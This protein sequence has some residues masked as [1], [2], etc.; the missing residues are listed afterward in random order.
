MPTEP[1]P[2]ASLPEKPLARI[3]AV[4]LLLL[5]TAAVRGGSPRPLET[6]Q[7][8]DVRR[9]HSRVIVKTA[10]GGESS[11]NW[12][13]ITEDD[14]TPVAP[15]RLDTFRMNRGYLGV[16]L[17]DLTPE[18]RQHFGA[19]A[20]SGVMISKVEEESPAER[21]NLKVADIITSFDG[22]AVAGSRQLAR[23]IASLDG[24]STAA[25]E[26][27]RDGRVSARSAEI[28]ERRRHQVDVGKVLWSPDGN[29]TLRIESDGLLLDAGGLRAALDELRLKMAGEDW[30]GRVLSFSRGQDQFQQRL[31]ALE[32][33]IRE[34][35]AE[36]DE[37]KN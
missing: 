25:L 7:E 34:L 3:L 12:V 4:L 20:D 11:Y 8:V 5:S 37:L 28:G 2:P 17:L 33:R 26:V 9:V 29:Q 23:R 15:I 10:E 36:L 27:W 14:E 13:V 35:E 31:L 6:D 21:A 16:L 19:P 32:E 18:L 30:G 1:A 24:G 22:D